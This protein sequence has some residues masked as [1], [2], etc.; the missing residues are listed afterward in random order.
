MAFHILP[1]GKIELIVDRSIYDDWVIDKVL[2]WWSSEYLITRNNSDDLRIQTIVLTPKSISAA[3]DVNMVINKISNDFIDYK[4]RQTIA[5]ET[6]NIR[7]LL[8]AKAFAN[9][10]DF[11]E[12]Y[13]CPLKLFDST[14]N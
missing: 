12:F 3:T 2:Y 4:N 11:I 13:Y 14:K 8:F 7:D 5:K 9:S 1:T 10:D 6:A